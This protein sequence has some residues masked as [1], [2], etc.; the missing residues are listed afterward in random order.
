MANYSKTTNFGTK[1]T[2]PTGDSQKIIRGSEFDTEFDNLVTAISTKL[3]SPASSANV[4]FLQSGAAAVSRTVQSKLRDVVSVKDF[5]AVGDGVA[6]DTAA[7]QAA[8]T[9]C[10]ANKT[11]LF[12]SNGTY[13]YKPNSTFD[14]N[15]HDAITSLKMFG[16]G[17]IATKFLID[18]NGLAFNVN[19]YWERGPLQLEDMTFELANPATNSN[20][21]GFYFR[22]IL[23]GVPRWGASWKIT[24][25]DFLKFT[26]CALHGVEIFNASTVSCNFV[27]NSLYT[28]SSG[29]LTTYDDACVR[30]WGA[31]GTANSQSHSFSNMNIFENCLFG[32]TKFGFD[33]WNAYFVEFNNCTFEPNWI[34]LSN[35]RVPTAAS[36][37]NTSTEKGGGAFASVT[38][39]NC[40]FEQNALYH[41]ADVEVNNSGAD[42]NPLIRSI[43]RG[44]NN[45]STQTATQN[46]KNRPS[47]NSSGFTTAL[48]MQGTS[49]ATT[50]PNYILAQAFTNNPDETFYQITPTA[51][52]W[53][54]P[55]TFQKITNIGGNWNGA[56]PVMLNNSGNSYH[57]W[58]D[59]S[60]KLRIKLGAPAA[61]ND[62]TVV[63]T[64]T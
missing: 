44:A 46:L 20:A 34:G 31:D 7:I 14:L 63:G 35:K 9:H 10:I 59:I 38:Y 18:F 19:N 24:N 23:S 50:D 4:N 30:M 45:Y 32:R 51:A 5:G 29:L 16:E 33:G 52:T 25:C 40:W 57:L 39:N 21:T 22:R 37:I 48:L 56:H 6:D 55:T 36:G 43:L 47:V 60:G 2:L 61:D 17:V 53:S 49:L 42:V 62:G 3:D 15:L 13:L 54:I 28:T 8:L 12:F 26:N 41:V 64:Q 27:G 58:V 11:S 1:D